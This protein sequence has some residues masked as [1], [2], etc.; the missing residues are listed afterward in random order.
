M[1]SDEDLRVT[2]A[3]CRQGFRYPTCVKLAVHTKHLGLRQKKE[4]ILAVRNWEK[5]SEKVAF[6]LGLSHR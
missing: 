6:E 3:L 4:F 5:L 2:F 1:E